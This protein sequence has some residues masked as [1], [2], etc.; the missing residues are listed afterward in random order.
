MSVQALYE[1]G[2][3]AWPAIAVDE[4][5]F[6]RHLERLGYASGEL[7]AGDLYLACACTLG[8]A[9]AVEEFDRAFMPKIGAF[10]ASVDSA[11]SFVEEVR[12]QLRDKLLVAPAGGA[13]KIA[14]YSGRGP[15]GGW[16]RVSAVR[17]AIDLQRRRRAALN[18]E[19]GFAETAAQAIDPEMA[20]IK[21]R[22]EG[23]FAHAIRHALAQLSARERNV[24]YLHYVDG[25]SI[26]R[27]GAQYKTHRATAAR[28]L[29]R[30]REKLLDL[31]HRGIAE[32]L[33]L[34][35]SEFVS[36][37]AVIRSQLDVSL[38]GLLKR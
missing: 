34:T 36:L 9:R 32:R 14:D 10:V 38:T 18:V 6:A 1:E 15:L 24:L 26:D 35:P 13:P 3:R 37:T 27:I 29:G 25:W 17:A 2:R 31:V 16:V 5:T 30:T 20:L 7:H 11:P 28:W 12:Q 19:G 4:A 22:Y 8:V 23:E 33:R 21:A